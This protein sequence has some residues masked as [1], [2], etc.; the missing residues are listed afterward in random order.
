MESRSWGNLTRRAGSSCPPVIGQIIGRTG[1][2][3]LHS[4]KQRL[5][6][7]MKGTPPERSH[8][9]TAVHGRASSIT[10][11]TAAARCRG[12]L[13]VGSLSFGAPASTFHLDAHPLLLLAPRIV[14]PREQNGDQWFSAPTTRLNSTPPA[15]SARSR[16][17]PARPTGSMPGPRQVAA[18][19]AEAARQAEP[20]RLTPCRSRRQRPGWQGAACHI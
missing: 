13:P 10:N 9:L 19:F 17:Q 8:V 2:P 6:G 4:A 12:N 14:A 18:G 7:E 20:L 5:I 16:Q 3:V 11:H 15:A 1:S